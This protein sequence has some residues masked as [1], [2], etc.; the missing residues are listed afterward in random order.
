MPFFAASCSKQASISKLD[1]TWKVSSIEKTT[2]YTNQS[3]PSFN[4]ATKESFDGTIYSRTHYSEGALNTLTYQYEYD[5][6][7]Y[8]F[9]KDNTY[10]IKKTW[11]ELGS[12]NQP[13]T[14]NEKGS[15]ALMGAEKTK[16][17]KKNSKILFNVLDLDDSENNINVVYDHGY[18][19][20]FNKVE[21]S[22]EKELHFSLTNERTTVNN[23]GTVV[24]EKVVEIIKLTK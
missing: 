19:N 15:F 5:E 20:Y 21:K 4:H 18:N 13:F 9:N 17:I 22:T 6:Y 23:D 16:D 14:Y 3:D 12:P 7:S 24:N 2:T 11:K 8:T 1:G 10:E